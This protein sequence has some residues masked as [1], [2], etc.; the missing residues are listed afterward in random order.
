MTLRLEMDGPGGAGIARLLIDRAD[1]RNAFTLAMWQQLPDLLAQAAANP[2]VRVL[3]VKSA[4][5]GAFCAGADIVELLANKDDAPWLAANQQAINRAQFDLT[6]FPLPTVA[7]VEGDCVG[8]G[9]GIALACDMRVAGPGARFGITP[10]KLGLVYPLHDVKLLVDLVGPGQA[11]RMLYTGMLLGAD[12]AKAVGLVEE[13]AMSEDALVAQVLAASPFST[14]ALKGFV[15]H[16][17][18][19]QVA[20]DAQSLGVFASAFAGADFREG[21]TAFLEKRKP[22]FGQ[23]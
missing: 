18:D 19:G 6:R 2:Q 8:G 4:H 9:C 7:M 1:K 3:V 23:G 20:D 5:G 10:A 16:V 22:R 11:R 14:Q 12:E 13:L 17:L 15:R 21:T